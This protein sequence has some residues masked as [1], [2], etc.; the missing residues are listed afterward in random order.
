MDEKAQMMVIESIVFTITILVALIFFYQ[1]SPT[2]T[3]SNIYTND[4]KIKGDDALRTLYND[5]VTVDLPK[6]FPKNKL[7]FYLIKDSYESMV[8]HLQS[9]L[10]SNTIFNIYISN[11]TNKT[12]WC[13]SAI[14]NATPLPVTEPVT[15]SHYI[16]SIH[17]QFFNQSK[18]PSIIS[19]DGCEIAKAFNVYK[20]DE[21]GKIDITKIR[22]DY[23]DSTYDVILEMFY[24]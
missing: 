22:E 15:I 5:Q 11:G 23:K 3:V 2:T 8:L 19:N 7:I 10:P 14:N 21:Y 24:T 1:L 17:P 16:I 20:M 18:F 13:S 12:F 9:K 6:N 4:L